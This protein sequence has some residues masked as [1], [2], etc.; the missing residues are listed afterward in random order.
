MRRFFILVLFFV[1][2]SHLVAAPLTLTFSSYNIR[3]ENNEDGDWR[4]W[5][6]RLYR[7]VNTIRRMN[8]DVLGVQEALHGQVADLR[9]SLP[10]YE[11][12]GIG[13]DDA[14]TKGEYSGI[15][16]K[17]ARFNADRSDA[18]TFWLSDTPEIPGSKTWGNEIPRIAAW[19]YLQD[20]QTSRGFT[21]FNTH[22]DHRNQASR[23]KAALLIA[24]RMD[25]RK[26]SHEPIVLLGDFNATEGNGAVD[27]LAGRSGKWSNALLDTYHSTHSGEKNRR[28]LHFWQNNHDGWAKV[29]HIMVSQ[30]SSIQSAAIIYPEGNAHPASDHF[31]VVAHITWP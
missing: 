12:Y 25:A 8:P 11:F 6:D 23:D 20:R 1:C 10:D 15:F 30:P 7:L 21:V 28:T 4:S 5:P 31:P 18:G 14:K 16:Y 22:W 24:K 29:D 27:Y 26:R 9:L 2:I 17:K 19:I 3:Y 13:R